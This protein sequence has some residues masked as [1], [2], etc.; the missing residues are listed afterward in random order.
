VKNGTVTEECQ[1]YSSYDKNIEKCPLKCK[2]G[3]DIVKYYAKN[4][5]GIINEYNENNY[6]DIV[7]IIMDQLINFGPVVSSII[8]YKDFHQLEGDDCFNKIYKYN[9]KSSKGNGH[10]VVIV[11]YGYENSKYYWIIQNS[12]GKSFCKDGFAKIEFGEISIERVSFSEPYID[13][14]TTEKEYD[15]KFNLSED[16]KLTFNTGL[17]TIE[18]SF[19]MNFNHTIKTNINFYYQ[20]SLSHLNKSNKKNEGICSYLFNNYYNNKGYYKFA[21][22]KPLQ[23]NNIFNLDFSSAQQGKFYFYGYDYIDYLFRTYEYISEEGSSVLLYFKSYSEDGRFVSKIYPTYQGS[24]ELN[25]GL[26]E[27]VTNLNKTL[28]IVHCKFNQSEINYL[29][30]NNYFSLIYDVLC[31]VKEQTQ[32]IIK[33]VNKTKYPVFRVNKVVLPEKKNINKNTEIVLLANIEGSLSEYKGNNEYNDSNYFAIIV[34]LQTDNYNLKVLGNCTIPFPSIL[35]N[36]YEIFCYL[37]FENNFNYEYKNIKIFPYTTRISSQSPMDVIINDN[38]EYIDFK[39][40]EN[41]TYNKFIRI[42]EGNSIKFCSISI[43]F[44]ALLLFL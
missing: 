27:N 38:I 13:Y 18:S 33:K 21:G 15:I 22:Y 2:N 8:A 4:A 35:E 39:E 24:K 43:I 9:G 20:C 1:P 7:S 11:G 40:N 19:E 32:I 17:T 41:N 34:E 14:N 30:K 36:D 31:G 23:N 3:S 5:Y 44:Y 12:W 37:N 10:A 42:N 25:C 29:E 6:Y 16:C 26:I 28:S